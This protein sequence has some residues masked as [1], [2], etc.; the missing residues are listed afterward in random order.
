M[1]RAAE[2]GAVARPVESLPAASADGAVPLGVSRSR[3]FLPELESLR[4]IA[5]ALVVA[6]HVDGYAMFMNEQPAHISPA[7]AFVRAGHTGVDLFFLLSGFL[8]ALPFL[9]DVS[10]GRRVNL[11]EY[12]VR[13]ALRI[14]PLYWLAVVVGTSLAASTPADLLH[15]VPYFFFLNSI[16]LASHYIGT[17]GAVWWSLGTEIQF[18]LLLPS[19]LLARTRAGRVVLGLVAVAYFAMYVR[20]VRGHLV[21][22]SIVGQMALINSV[23]GRGP[24][25][26]WG[27]AAA[28]VYRRWGATLRERLAASRVLRNG[29]ADVLMVAVFVVMAF[30][31]RWLVGIG[32]VRQMG[33][34]DQPW[35]IV[36]GALW[37]AVLLLILLAPLRAKGLFANRVL[38][39]LGVLSYS[40]Y[41][42]H[43][44]FV[45]VSL[46]AIRKW[47]PFQ[48]VGW[49]AG[50]SITIAVLLLALV[51]VSSL[52]YRYIESPFLV[53]KARFDS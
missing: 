33:A 29:G 32:A 1:S 8:L 50:S 16:G 19:L 36:N 18:Y 30:F 15:G 20:L 39:R 5:V 43:V 3:S 31:L 28:V 24:L 53:R 10:G 6:F 21:M 2:A 45:G 51:G 42:I 9:A 44:P 14:L 35:H 12:F 38:G 7:M 49:D 34:P 11:R 13:R 41:M 46:L 47:M 23:F 52:T 40:I 37:A 26:L 17:Y 27:I 25:F 22:G 4:G 48:M